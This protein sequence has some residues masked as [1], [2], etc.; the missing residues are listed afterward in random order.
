MLWYKCWREL[1]FRIL[2]GVGVLAGV[3]AVLVLKQGGLRPRN[4]AYATYLWM[5]MY[6]NVGLDLFIVM[7]VILGSGGLLQ[8]W[9]QGTAGF[10]LALPASRRRV[11]WT[12]VL[13]GYAGVVAMA[14][15]P[16]VLIPL[17]S[18]MAEQHYPFWQA[19]QF[20]IV[21]ASCG[22][23]IYALTF[24]YAH[25][26]HDEYT[27][28]LCAMGTAMV[29]LIVLHSIGLDEIYPKLNFVYDLSGFQA[30]GRAMPWFNGALLEFKDPFPWT[31]VAS[32]LLLAVLLVL[33]AVRRMEKRDF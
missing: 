1:R 28:M 24:F 14:F 19:A 21:W 12:R 9:A 6:M 30:F 20:G 18:P 2:S 22:A 16:A 32:L 27:P 8:E 17:L 23:V 15:V 13:V 5:V 4:F 31:L 7:C 26:M 25:W 33:P 11:M 10:T 3:S 29:Y